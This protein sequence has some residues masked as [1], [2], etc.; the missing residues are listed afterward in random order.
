MQQ[1]VNLYGR[2][3]SYGIP[4]ITT[5]ATYSIGEIYHSFSKALLESERP[6][7][8]NKTEL[9]QYNILLEDKSFPF[10]DKAIEFLS[11]NLRHVKESIYDDWIQKSYDRLIQLYPVRYK[12]DVKLEPYINVLH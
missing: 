1:A 3:S 4:S 9:E 2:A 6:K 12:R 11:T 8:L 5:E 7:N 10:D